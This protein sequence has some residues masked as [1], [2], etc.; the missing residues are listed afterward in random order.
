MCQ[1]H[2]SLFLAACGLIMMSVFAAEA[3]NLFFS[4]YFSILFES[5]NIMKS[6]LS[7]FDVSSEELEAFEKL[8]GCYEVGGVYKIHLNPKI[9]VKSS[10]T[11]LT[12]PCSK[13][14]IAVY[15]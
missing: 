5:K 3:C 1:E 2:L 11:S 6:Q 14:W 4:V 7:L 8:Q 13:L 15:K 10:L 9:L 12:C